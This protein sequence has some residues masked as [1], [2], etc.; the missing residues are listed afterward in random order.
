MIPYSHPRQANF[1]TQG[2]LGCFRNRL[3]HNL[4]ASVGFLSNN[5]K[6]PLV[7]LDL[8]STLVQSGAL[9]P[10]YSGIALK[11]EN[12]IHMVHRN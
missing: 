12:F 8:G 10:S 2:Q 11:C 5:K 3:F 6:L 7:G 9:P 4:D 1:P